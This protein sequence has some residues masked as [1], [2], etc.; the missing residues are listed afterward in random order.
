MTKKTSKPYRMAPLQK[1]KVRPIKDPAEQAALDEKLKRSEEAGASE[2]RGEDSSGKETPLAVLEL[3][4]HLSAKERLLVANGLTEQ[5]SLNQR[6]KLLELLTT[7]LPP[8][9]LDEF[10]EHFRGQREV[11]GDCGNNTRMEQ[12]KNRSRKAMS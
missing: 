6:I 5:L 1:L 12:S 3:C 2:R 4:R 11:L 8:K 9:A 10:E 7:Q